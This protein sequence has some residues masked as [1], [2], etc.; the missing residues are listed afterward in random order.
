MTVTPQDLARRLREAREAAGLKQ[1]DVAR[2]LGMSRSSVAQIELGNRAVSSLELDLLARLYGRDIRDFLAAE[3]HPEDS[4]IALFR[5]TPG[6]ADQDA[7]L[8][9]IRDCIVLARELAGLER[10]LGVDRSHLGVPAYSVGQPRT[11]WQAVEQGTRVATEERRRLGLG[12]RPLGDAVELL[13]DQG[14]RTAMIDLPEDI[15]G[16]TLMERDI[17]LFVVANR[18]HHQLRRRFSWVHEYAHVLLDRSRRGTISRTEDRDDLSEV[19]ANAFAANFLLPEEGIRDFL[20]NLGKGQPG[21]ERFEV[22][23]GEE[24]VSAETR[25]EP[26]AQSLQL[27][28]VVLLAHHFRVSR[29]AALYRLR[30]L[31][32]LSQA[33]LER[34]LAEEGEGKGERIARHLQ[35]RDSDHAAARNEFRSRFLG[36]A[37]E[38][39][40]QEKISRGKLR[41]LAALVGVSEDE[42]EDLL[43]DAGLDDEERAPN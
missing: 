25:A 21:R 3:F 31:R 42:A 37:L 22:F 17:S 27:Y 39:Y 11:K 14:I 5:A 30:N 36:L 7:V 15:S 2:H 1:E 34:L 38:A 40:R 43:V 16:L 13:E 19:R 26:G 6:I 35:L 20:A 24:A 29:T 28:D 23:D 18:E 4:V 41:E 32:L 8:E 33:A 12:G 10:L 9:A